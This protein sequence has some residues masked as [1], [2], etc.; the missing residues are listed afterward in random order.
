VRFRWHAS[1]MADNPE[2]AIQPGA[3]GDFGVAEPELTTEQIEP[4]RLLANEVRDRLQGAG[5]SNDQINDWADAFFATHDEG[6]GAEF[7][8]WIQA[9]QTST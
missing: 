7:L 6:G 2:L 9:Q 3:P 5:L 4:S 8:A 1:G